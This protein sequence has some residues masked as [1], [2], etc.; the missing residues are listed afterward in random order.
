MASSWWEICLVP[1]HALWDG[2]EL[3]LAPLQTQNDRE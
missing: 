3:P 1:G 2:V